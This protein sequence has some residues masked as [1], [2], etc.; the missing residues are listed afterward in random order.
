MLKVLQVNRI[1]YGITAKKDS[2]LV[3]YLKDN[4]IPFDISISSNYSTSAVEKDN[5]HPIK[6]FIEKGVKI[7]VSTDIPIH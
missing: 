6:D 7:L 2:N 5:I 4:N 3:K 1:I